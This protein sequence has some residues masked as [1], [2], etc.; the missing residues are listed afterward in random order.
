MMRTVICFVL[1]FFLCRPSGAQELQARISVMAGKVS[2]QENRKALQTLQAGLNTFLNNRKWSNDIYQSQEKIKCNF[3]LTIEEELNK[4][5]YRATLTVQAARPVYNTSYESP[6]VNF[7][8]VDVVFRYVEFQPIEFNEN[9]I[10]GNDPLAANLMAILAYYSNII[11]GMDYASFSPRSGDAFFQ[12]AQFIVNNAPESGEIKGWKPFDGA[13]NRNRFRLVEGLTDSRFTL[14]HD[15]LYSYYR[16]GLDQ[17]YQN[18]AEG[19][20]GILNA[21]SY[22][23]TIESENPGA[24]VLP[25]FFQGKSTELV[26][27]FSKADSDTRTRARDLL[28][29]LDLTN[30]SAYKELK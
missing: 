28:V 22:L 16:S 18:E 30:A 26:K 3:L 14:V 6:I 4:N 7:Q 10:Q 11:L 12:K 24:M 19:R 27:V 25:F 20:N 8:D 23:N 5:V 13:G 21:L 15:A 29:K 1:A 9:R 2:T 17:F